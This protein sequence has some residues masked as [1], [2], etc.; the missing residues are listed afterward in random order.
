M[1][2]KKGII[3]WTAF[4]VIFMAAS[5]AC[6]HGN[7]ELEINQLRCSV[8]NVKNLLTNGQ[9][10]G[11]VADID[12]Q[13]VI[14]TAKHI[15]LDRADIVDIP[16][17]GDGLIELRDFN[18]RVARVRMISYDDQWDIDTHKSSDWIILTCPEDWYNLPALTLSNESPYFGE[19]AYWAGFSDT[20]SAAIAEEIIMGDEYADTGMRRVSGVF[21]GGSS[22]SP[23]YDP[24]LGVVGIL[25]RTYDDSGHGII[26]D[27][28]VIYDHLMD[29]YAGDTVVF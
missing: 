13:H 8:V 3:L 9:G 26:V 17:F 25:V 24:D 12:S 28:P 18:G 21:G 15:F 11:W 29:E 4:V 2:K 20:S 1:D 10:T 23:I 16:I 19:I 5:C 27:I 7:R 14:I 6:D 22:G